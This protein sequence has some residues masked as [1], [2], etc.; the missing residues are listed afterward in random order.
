MTISDHTSPSLD[1][2]SGHADFPD[3]PAFYRS[4][5]DA[6]PTPLLV[7]DADGLVVYGNE[8]LMKL[9]GRSKYEGLRSSIY[10][11]VHPDDLVRIADAFITLATA[12]DEHRAV[13]APWSPIRCRVL[14]PD[15]GAMSVEIVGFDRLSRPEING[16][17]YEIRPMHERE[18]V[19]QVMQASG[20]GRAS[21]FA[22]VIELLSMSNLDIASAV[23]SLDSGGNAV[24]HASSTDELAA[25]L[26]GSLGSLT[27]LMKA[28]ESCEP[29]CLE[30][31]EVPGVLG[32]RWE[33]LG[34]RHV[35]I[36]DVPSPSHREPH[37]ILALSSTS[38]QSNLGVI[39]RLSL[40]RDLTNVI[41]LRRWATRSST[42]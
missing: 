26:K 28:T 4:V 12:G 39:D 20:D 27:Q 1:I 34:F 15:G 6:V 13:S 8:A 36:V 30:P 25:T 32:A 37:S 31:A 7:A 17:I 18:I 35:W 14:T 11:Y 16:F 22:P 23:V 3:D 9:V 24:V 5:L 40:T 29:A 2:W 19:R 10:D 33:S 21:S 41:L 42:A 38:Q